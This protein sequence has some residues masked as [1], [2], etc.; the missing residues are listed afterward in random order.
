MDTAME[1][2]PQEI[3]TV[4]RHLEA[5]DTKI[6]DIS[7]DS[8]SI[9]ADVA[10]FRDKVTDLDH[11]LHNIENRMAELPDHEPELQSLHNKLM[12]LENRNHK[13]NVCF[14]GLQEKTEGADMRAF[15]RDPLSQ[16]S[17]FLPPR[18][19]NE[20]IGLAPYTTVLQRD[21]GP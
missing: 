1:R 12:D 19:F 15:L 2:I 6:T 17:L 8:N 21:S 11:H 18:N 4:G 20:P 13:D 16:A 9:R 7:A 5:M 3:S 14:F 10:G